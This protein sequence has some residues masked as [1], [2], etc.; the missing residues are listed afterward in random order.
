MGMDVYG[1]RP[2]SK[3]GKYFRANVVEWIPLWDYIAGHYPGLAG[4]VPAAYHND[5]DGLGAKDSGKLGK[6]LMRD[7]IKGEVARYIDGRNK[8]FATLPDEV[9]YCRKSTKLR[10]DQTFEVSEALA[11]AS[12]M[13][14][15]VTQMRISSLGLT[16]LEEYEAMENYVHQKW[17]HAPQDCGRCHGTGM[18]RSLETT[19]TLE[20]GTVR[21]FME[22]LR[23]CGG[24]EIW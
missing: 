11:P 10:S 13:G 8:Y 5:G 17:I 1:Q 23:H 9:C 22:F 15:P 20:L 16:P 3:C 18:K 2:D 14:I 4:K 21:W 6:L 24:F 12:Y 7:V 19:L